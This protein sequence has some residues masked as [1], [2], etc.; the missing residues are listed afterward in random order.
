[1]STLTEIEA[2]VKELR[3][4]R[5]ELISEIKAHWRD[6]EDHNL[7]YRMDRLQEIHEEIEVEYMSYQDPE[8]E[9]D[10]NQAAMDEEIEY[11]E[12]LDEL[13]EFYNTL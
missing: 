6:F 2:K 5:K 9:F 3:E 7:D 13:T 10:C 12:I 4:Q 1:M 8:E 11:C